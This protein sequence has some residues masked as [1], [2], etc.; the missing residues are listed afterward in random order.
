MLPL[1]AGVKQ[2]TVA[3]WLTILKTVNPKVVGAL[4]PALAAVKPE[5]VSRL[6]GAVNAMNPGAVVGLANALAGLTPAAWD[7][8]LKLVDAGVPAINLAGAKLALLPFRVSAP[9]PYRRAE[10]AAAAASKSSW[11]LPFGRH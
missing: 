1:L 8:L 6:I 11:H 4:V 7:A 5:T 2:E 10:P 3:K 9:A